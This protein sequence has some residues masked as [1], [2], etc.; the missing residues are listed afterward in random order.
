MCAAGLATIAYYYYFDFRDVKKQDR[1][2]LLPSLVSQ[3]STELDSCFQ[4]NAAFAAFTPGPQR[5]TRTTGRLS[6]PLS[7]GWTASAS[8]S[9]EVGGG[10][11]FTSTTSSHDLTAHPLAN[12]S[13]DQSKK[14]LRQAT[15]PYATSSGA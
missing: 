7:R 12:D 6:H 2:S 11:S 13:F 5:R 10:V 9:D 15:Q 3:L 14:C 4:V 1:Y 8:E